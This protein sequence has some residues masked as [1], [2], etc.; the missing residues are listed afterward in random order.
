MLKLKRNTM[1]NL[2]LAGLALCLSVTSIYAQLKMLNETLSGVT[3]QITTYPSTYDLINLNTQYLQLSGE[4]VEPN[5]VLLNTGRWAISKTANDAELIILVTKSEPEITIDV[6][7]SGIVI[8]GKSDLTLKYTNA[9]KDEKIISKREVISVKNVFEQQGWT[10]QKYNKYLNENRD[11]L[12]TEVAQQIIEDSN[13]QLLE[14]KKSYDVTNYEFI[15]PGMT[16]KQI[17]KDF[18][19]LESSFEV[20][21]SYNTKTVSLDK[22]DDSDINDFKSALAS[23]EKVIDEHDP[24]K[25]KQRVDEDAYRTLLQNKAILD[26]FLRNFDEATNSFV[27]SSRS[28]SLFSIAGETAGN[29]QDNV[30]ILRATYLRVNDEKGLKSDSFWN[31]AIELIIADGSIFKDGGK[32][33]MRDGSIIEDQELN[34]EWTDKD[35]VGNQKYDL[36]KID[37]VIFSKAPEVK[38]QVMPVGR[39]Y[40]LMARTNP[41]DQEIGLYISKGNVG[42][43][44][45]EDMARFIKGPDAE[46]VVSIDG[47]N[48][49]TKKLLKDQ[50][51]ECEWLKEIVDAKHK[52]YVIGA[53]TD[54]SVKYEIWKNM[55]EAYH[56]NCGVN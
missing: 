50:I 26:L 14:W 12:E 5:N 34:Y 27:L 3:V 21:K 18:P 54:N 13:D 24:G 6:E 11:R 29:A 1:K 46:E 45:D 42:L 10:I 22:F 30:R 51:K 43:T 25:K 35:L 40:H 41:D 7:S 19:E 28:G 2:F 23:I 37:Y 15:I 39:T 31:D 44:A 38:F 16:K 47:L 49:I 33:F 48:A 20:I 52:S 8:K 53:L 55:A 4:G 56:S 17:G 36:E 9:K 32:I